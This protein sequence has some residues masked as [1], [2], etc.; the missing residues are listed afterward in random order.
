MTSDKLCLKWHDFTQN[1]ASSYN[2][3]RNVPDFSDVTLV[4][5]DDQLIEAHRIILTSC[6]QFF[7]TVLRRNMHTHPMIYM[8]GLKAKDL[9]AVVDFIY[10]G[11][12]NIDQEDLERF[13]AL[14]EELQLKGLADSS[15][16]IPETTEEPLEKSKEQNIQQALVPKIEDKREFKDCEENPILCS[17][18]NHTVIYSKDG[19]SSSPKKELADAIKITVASNTST[20]DLKIKLDSMMERIYEGEYSWKCTVC[21]KKTKG[22]FFKKNMR[23][24]IETHIEGMSYP[25]N[26]CGKVSRTSGSL[27]KHISRHHRE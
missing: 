21:G 18:E 1:I 3:L 22:F 24:H 16:N 4:C 10:H 13:L 9:V 17:V 23:T 5:E 26:Q 15:E 27:Q 19:L 8:R 2:D 7:S 12:A 14:A 6:S 25:C 20:E 11:E